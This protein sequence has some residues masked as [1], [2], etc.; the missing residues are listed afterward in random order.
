MASLVCFL[1][2]AI[3]FVN[4]MPF[5][6]DWQVVV[7][8]LVFVQS[9]VLLFIGINKWSE[10]YS[11]DEY[12]KFS[13]TSRERVGM[14]VDEI[15]ELNAE[16]IDDETVVRERSQSVTTGQCKTCG[17]KVVDGKCSYC[18]N[19]YEDDSNILKLSY[20]TDYGTKE[21]TF[22]HGKLV[23]SKISL[24]PLKDVLNS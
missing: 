23:G 19:I 9:I 15:R 11:I 8:D 18:G 13:D 1:A 6:H 5:D 3:M 16:Y 17:G 24:R 12:R 4:F 7:T 2:S 22:N 10:N 14:T 20:S 21:F